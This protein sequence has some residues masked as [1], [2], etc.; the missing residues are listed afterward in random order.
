M[1]LAIIGSGYVGLVSGICFAKL[2][3]HVVLIDQDVTK[4][5]GLKQG[6]TPIFEPGIQEGLEEGLKSNNL[7]FTTNFDVLKDADIIFLAV[8]TPSRRGDGYADL[9]Y[10]YQALEDIAPFMRE[11]TVIVTKS[12]VPV[13]TGREIESILKRQTGHNQIHIASNPEFLREGSAL[14]DFMEPSRIVL[15]VDTPFSKTQMSRVYQHFLEQDI[16]FV[17]TSLESSELIKYT[18]NSFLALKIAFMNEIADL[19]EKTEANVF[20]VI[21][22]ISLDPRIGPHCLQPGPGYGGSCFPKD[23]RALTQ[24]AN[25]YHMPLYTVNAAIDANQNHIQNI[26]HRIIAAA[27]G[28]ART[29]TIAVWGLSF[30]ANTDD[31]RESAALEIVKALSSQGYTIKVY[32]PEAMESAKKVL[33]HV[34]FSTSAESAAEGADVLVVLTEWNAFKHADFELIK[35]HMK[36][37]LVLDYRNLLDENL[38]LQLGFNYKGLGK[39]SKMHSLQTQ[40]VA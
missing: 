8:G 30:K 36:G 7:N 40:K 32:D 22:G 26:I 18:A 5:E 24:L 29:K 20:D 9:S 34:D 35:N 19:C 2:G 37:T 15:G 23:T 16:P 17:W 10:V 33:T 3:H 6:K 31:I 28:P 4:I 11:D 25:H 1:K 39:P 27:Q 12:T 38:L 21:E 13:G 14:Q